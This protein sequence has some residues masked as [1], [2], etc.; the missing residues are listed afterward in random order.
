MTSAT[1]KF[2][3]AFQSRA[4]TAMTIVLLGLVAGLGATGAHA[5]GPGEAEVLASSPVPLTS[6]AV[7][8]T[9]GLIYGL[10]YE[11]SKAFRFDP[12]TDAW[13]ELLEAPTPSGNNGG[14][15][16]LNGKLYAS[17][18]E[19]SETLEVFDI[20]TETWSQVANPLGEGTTDITTAGEEIYMA[21][22]TH[23]VKY[24][25]S[26]E[27]IT[28]LANAPT[29]P[30]AGCGVGFEQW[31]GLQ[32]YNG[33]I[34]GDQGDGCRGFASYDIA[35]DSWSELQ[36][37]PLE[38]GATEGPVAGSALDP[39]SGTFFAYGGYEGDV[40]FQYD[41]AA[42]TW[43]TYTLPFNVNDGGLVHVDLAGHSGIYAIQGQ[44]GNEFV[45]F[46]TRDSNP[47]PAP[48][49]PAAG[50]PVGA[51]A[52]VAPAPPARCLSAR[53]E[54]LHWKAPRRGHLRSIVITVNGVLYKRLPGSARSAEVSLAG[55][56]A[57][58]VVVEITGASTT[59]HTGTSMR[60]FHPCA[61]RR[62]AGAQH[63]LYLRHRRSK[64]S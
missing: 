44:E 2:A 15:T 1:P 7:D 59:G 48:A 42:A 60:V 57:G 29:F 62:A 23:F 12:R 13:T 9:S 63:S 50:P 41:I 6:L 56:P 18:S 21:N 4:V 49:P 14:A 8:P 30:A 35:E 11:G 10:E 54:S 45:R 5:A 64:H 55:R 46:V 25:P 36:E 32:S 47:A 19:N 33:K 27:K 38:D 24:N 37:T 58:T 34:Y 53:V 40:L 31:G 26:T 16:Y 51:P 61:A 3:L 52:P 39:V 17:S 28:T 43:S 22:E 20:G